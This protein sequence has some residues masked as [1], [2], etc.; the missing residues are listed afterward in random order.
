MNLGIVTYKRGMTTIL[1]EEGHSIPV[2]LVEYVPMTVVQIKTE[3]TDK[4]SAIQVG[5]NPT[6]DHR[7]TRAEKVHQAKTV[8]RD[9]DG[10]IKDIIYHEGGPFHNLKEFRVDSAMDFEIGQV[11]S[12]DFI[13]EGQIVDAIGT[14]KGKGFAGGMKRHHFRGQSSSHGVSKTHRKPMSGGATDAART[15]KGKRGPGHMGN[16]RYTQKNLK[17]VKIDTDL[18]LFAIQGSVPGPNGGEIVITPAKRTGH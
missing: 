18:N 16:V 5:Y 2:T 8:K 14:T 9:K 7:L 13:S 12:I 6:R 4:Y 11:V 15:F 3:A 10:K 17:V 1:T